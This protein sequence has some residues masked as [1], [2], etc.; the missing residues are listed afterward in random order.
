MSEEF[1]QPISAMEM[2][3]DELVRIANVSRI[4]GNQLQTTKFE[5]GSRRLNVINNRRDCYVYAEI[6]PFTTEKPFHEIPAWRAKML[7]QA[8]GP[9]GSKGRMKLLMFDDSMFDDL[10]EL[11]RLRLDG[12]LP[13]PDLASV[14]PHLYL[15]SRDIERNN[16]PR[17]SWPMASLQEFER[18]NKISIPVALYLDDNGNPDR[19]K[20]AAS[21]ESAA[22]TVLAH[23]G[24]LQF[25]TLPVMLGT[26]DED[27]SFDPL[28]GK[29]Q[30]VGDDAIERLVDA[31]VKKHG[32]SL[33]EMILSRSS[34]KGAQSK[35]P[36]VTDKNKPAE[37]EDKPKPKQRKTL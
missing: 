6:P 2:Y 10:A 31:L 35:T 33:A 8:Y 32:D 24:Q 15:N 23:G 3:G 19:R 17:P 28:A 21:L 14:H 34:D 36:E 1:G 5:V 11:E 9:T 18:V 12:R 7:Y 4:K 29:V 25:V 30:D 16:L 27:D 37:R 22:R 20:Y 13:P 26:E